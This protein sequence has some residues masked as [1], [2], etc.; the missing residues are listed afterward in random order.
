MYVCS[1]EV[2]QEGEKIVVKSLNSPLPV[3]V[4]EAL[5][6]DPRG[7]SVLIACQFGKIYIKARD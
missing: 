6:A 5:R 4:Q 1:A 2:L 7:I 3:Q